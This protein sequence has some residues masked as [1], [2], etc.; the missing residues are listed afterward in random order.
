MRVAYR[1][2]CGGVLIGRKQLLEDPLRLAVHIS[3]PCLL[4]VKDRLQSA[5]AHI[6][7]K[8]RLLLAR[9]VTLLLPQLHKS[10]QRG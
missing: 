2:K 6:T 5:P 3:S 8:S 10:A 7:G 4:H 1:A 9:W